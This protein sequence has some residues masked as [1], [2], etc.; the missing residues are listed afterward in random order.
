MRHE[1][2]APVAHRRKDR[3]DPVESEID[4]SR[5]IGNRRDDLEAGPQTA[6][7]R[8]R[9]CMPAEV[10]EFKG[11]RFLYCATRDP[12]GEIQMIT[13]AVADPKDVDDELRH[14]ISVISS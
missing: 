11:K 5:P 2:L 6:R 12:K 13:G 7:S 9:D 4:G 1:R 14:L 8:Q 3:L 10:V